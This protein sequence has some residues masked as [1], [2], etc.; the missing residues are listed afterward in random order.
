M[1][2]S[3]LILRKVS[4]S[5]FC[6]YLMLRKASCLK[7]R[8]NAKAFQFATSALHS[9]VRSSFRKLLSPIHLALKRKYLALMTKYLPLNKKMKDTQLDGSAH[10]L[11]IIDR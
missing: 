6:F 2:S 7:V 9:T 3:P 8:R 5:F 10:D 11:F 4:C 1:L